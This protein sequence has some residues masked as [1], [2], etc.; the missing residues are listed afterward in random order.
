MTISREQIFQILSSAG[1][2]RTYSC[3]GIEDKLCSTDVW[4][5]NMEAVVKIAYSAGQAAELKALREQEPVATVET[6]GDK[7]GCIAWAGVRIDVG[8]KLYARPHVSPRI[9]ATHREEADEAIR[10]ALGEA[11]DCESSWREGEMKRR[12]FMPVACCD[13]RVASIRNAAF[14]VFD[15]HLPDDRLADR[16]IRD[17]AFKHGLL[18]EGADINPD[19]MEFAREIEAASLSINGI[20]SALFGG[21]LQPV[22]ADHDNE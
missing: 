6:S 4:R 9:S 14:S 3:C 12:D 21:E 13:D 11:L 8:V 2:T 16:F 5:G 22:E 1:A 15:R 10:N 7:G 18:Q 20:E 19:V 17:C